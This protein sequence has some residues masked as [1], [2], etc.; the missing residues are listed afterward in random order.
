MKRVLLTG[1]SGFVGANLARRLILEGHE[2]HLFLRQGYAPWRLNGISAQCKLHLLDLGDPDQVRAEVAAVQPD[3]VFHLAAFGAYSSQ[4]SLRQMIE[5]NLMATVNLLDACAA[6]GFEVFLNTGSSSEYG[7][8]DHAP[9]ENE[10]LEPNS[11]YAV[12]KAAATHYCHAI[13]RS[14][15]LNLATLRLY[16]VYGP[17]EEPTRLIPTMIIEGLQGRL[18]PLVNPQ[19]ARDFIY[20]EDVLNAY[21]LAAQHPT[22]IAGKVYNIGTGLQTNLE[23]VVELTRRSLSIPIQPQWGTMDDRKWDTSVWVADHARI[24][25]DLGWEPAYSFADGFQQTVNWFI[26]CPEIIDFY[27]NH[28]D[29][30]K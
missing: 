30:P 26:S 8:K 5:T 23:Q 29:V 9:N 24:S 19:V 12:S 6:V 16:S 10:C 21:L 2:I 22:T 27:T 14:K 17:F 25:K 15:N 18:P 13:T 7:F 4:T 20:V 11:S 1:A 3:W 28:P